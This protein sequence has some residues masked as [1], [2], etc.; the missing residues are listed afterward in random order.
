MQTNS[1]ESGFKVDRP[2]RVGLLEVADNG[3]EAF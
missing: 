3:N 2:V 1:G